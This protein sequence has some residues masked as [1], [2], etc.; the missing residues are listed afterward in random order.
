MGKQRYLLALAVIMTFSF[1]TACTQSTNSGEKGAETSPTSAVQ[2]G[3]PAEAIQ[4]GTYKFETPVT[5]TTVKATDATMKFKNG[6]T[7]ENNVHTKWAHDQLGVDM[8]V[9]WQVPGEQF[10]TKLRLML[11]ANESLPDVLTT[12]DMTLLDELIQSGKYRDITADFEKYASPKMKQIYNSNPLNWSQVTYGGKK[13]AIPNFAIAGNDNPVMWI[14]QDWLDKLG[15]KA[16]KTFEELEAV[17]QAFLEKKPG[18]SDNVIPLGASLG[19]GGSSPNPFTSWLGETSW[20]FG[21]LGTVPY[22]W[23]E[24]DGKLIHGSTLPAMKDGL[25]KLRDWY[26]KGYLSKEAGLHDENK[27]AELIAQGRVGI[28]VAPS[29]MSGWPNTDMQKNVA[30]SIMK[31]YPLPTLNGK[32]EARDTTYLRGG[33]L[34]KKDFEHVDALFLYLNRIFAAVN[35]EEGSE[36]VNGWAKDYDYTIKADGTYSV[37]EA[38]IPGGKVSPA[39]YLLIEPKDP[40]ISM[41]LRADVSRGKA[42]VT[43]SEKKIAVSG[44]DSLKAAEI[45]DDGWKAGIYIPQAYTGANT[46]AMQSKGGILVK[47][48]GDTFI[49]IIYGKKPVTEFDNFVKEWKSLGGDDMTKEVNDWYSK[50]KK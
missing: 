9:L 33:L 7:M 32:I 46:P 8:K 30:G 36:F 24:K 1:V 16:P 19:S 47:L 10:N 21:A 42:P 50:M 48:E 25:S 38:D 34:V 37:T 28:V 6:E 2:K 18:G 31:P 39:K 15:I 4:K 44:Q 41:K 20:V 22:Q 17:M 45:V 13:M 11:T 49:N 12:Q 5:I 26:N 40:F 3:A 14:R 35:P 27:L 43:P 23:L 29:W